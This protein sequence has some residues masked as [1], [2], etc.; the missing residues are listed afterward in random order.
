MTKSLLLICYDSYEMLLVVFWFLM[1]LC[2]LF[3]LLTTELL[4]SLGC[5][6]LRLNIGPRSLENFE[7]FKVWKI[8]SESHPLVAIQSI[9][10]GTSL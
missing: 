3:L 10:C 2:S 6:L 7:E 9:L 5:E 8:P 1:D 4:I